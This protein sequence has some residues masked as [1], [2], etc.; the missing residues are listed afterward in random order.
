MES[1]MLTKLREASLNH[2]E[3]KISEPKDGM[4]I[5]DF[6]AGSSA[7]NKLVKGMIT[8]ENVIVNHH[9]LSIMS[10]P[11][12]VLNEDDGSGLV[13]G[14]PMDPKDVVCILNDP[15]LAHLA[16]KG[17]CDIALADGGLETFNSMLGQHAP[18]LYKRGIRLYMK[19]S[20]DNDSMPFSCVL[21]ILY[22]EAHIE[23]PA[24]MDM[25]VMGVMWMKKSLT[26]DSFYK[27][28]IGGEYSQGMVNCIIH[29][30]EIKGVKVPKFTDLGMKI[31][32]TLRHNIVDV[33]TLLDYNNITPRKLWDMYFVDLSADDIPHLIEVKNVLKGMYDVVNISP[34][35]TDI[36]GT[37]VTQV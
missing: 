20:E 12:P 9:G 1:N 16:K 36:V 5:M 37:L 7:L 13:Y 22:S 28:V 27:Y 10:S 3:V 34:E 33:K 18:E 25:V 6:S 8:D 15:K 31:A 35:T 17:G 30:E 26:P 4:V 19:W 24:I 29:S 23:M 14:I 11:R 32:R 21:G 2:K